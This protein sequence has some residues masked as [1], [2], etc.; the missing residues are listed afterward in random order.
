MHAAKPSGI[1]HT[2]RKRK[3]GTAEKLKRSLNRVCELLSEK[4]V[5]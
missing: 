1:F 5:V 3:K 2:S 4:K